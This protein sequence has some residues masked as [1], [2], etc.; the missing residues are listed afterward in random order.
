MTKTTYLPLLLAIAFGLPAH[1]SGSGKDD[2]ASVV[3][4]MFDAF[5]RHD[6]Q[7]MARLYAPDVWL[8]SSD[9]CA[10]RQ[11]REAVRRTYQALF[12]ET[13]DITDTV[14]ELIVQGEKV[15]VR[16][17]ASGSVGGQAFELPIATFITVSHGL[18]VRDQS[19]FRPPSSTCSR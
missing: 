2:P 11:G 10:P 17:H 16:F 4:S 7:G 13:P 14:D 8:D 18:I 12:D 1:A 3:H 6:A 19:L 9:F 15:A 5:N